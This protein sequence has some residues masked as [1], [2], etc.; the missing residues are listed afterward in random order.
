MVNNRGYIYSEELLKEEQAKLFSKVATAGMLN[1]K[2]KNKVSS[3]ILYDKDLASIDETAVIL[4]RGMQVLLM[5][6][7]LLDLNV[8][9]R[10]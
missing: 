9:E 5:N 10:G 6:L 3:A 1:L 2:R 4:N 7:F 8:S